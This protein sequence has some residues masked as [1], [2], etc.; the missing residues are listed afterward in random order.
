MLL[1]WVYGRL[2]AW[3]EVPACRRHER[4]LAAVGTTRGLDEWHVALTDTDKLD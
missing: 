3:A 4:E 2:R 1:P